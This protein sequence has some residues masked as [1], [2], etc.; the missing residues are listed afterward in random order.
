MQ[1][2]FLFFFTFIVVANLSWASGLKGHVYNEQNEPLAFVNVYVP[3]IRKGTTTNEEGYFK[4]SLPAGEYAVD[5]HFIGYEKKRIDVKVGDSF[6]DLNIIL[7]SEEIKIKEVVVNAGEDPAYAIMRKVIEKREYHLNQVKSFK[8]E[9][10]VKGLQRI[11]S[12]PDKIMGQSV[13]I[14]GV[15][16]SNNSGII[17]LSES[18]S[19][20]YFKAPDKSKE[21]IKSSKVSGNSQGFTWNST[22]GFQEFNFYKNNFQFDFL[23]DRLFVSPTSDNAFFYYDYKLEGFFEEDGHIINKIKVIPKRENDPVFSGYLYIVED[24][25]NIHSL[26]L[27]LTKKN[28]IKF[29]DTLDITQNYF[30]LNDTLWMPFSQRFDFDFNI[31]KIQAEGYFIAVYRDYD[32]NPD[33]PDD[34]FDNELLSFKDS[35]NQLKNDFWEKYRPIPLTETE[36]KDYEK[37]EKL[38]ELRKSKSYLDSMDRINNSFTPSALVLGYTYQRSY[39]KWTIQTKSLLDLVQY[40]NVE[41]FNFRLNLDIEKRFD[42]GKKLVMNP[43]FR[44]GLENRHFNTFLSTELTYKPK[45]FGKVG[46]DFGQYVFQFNREKPIMELVNTFYALFYET[47]YLK[48]YQERFINAS[49]SQEVFNGFFLFANVRYG[50]R[51]YLQNTTD[52]KVINR[53]EVTFSDNQPLSNE[54]NGPYVDHDHAQLRLRAQYRPGQ[55]YISRPNQK[56]IFESKWPTF[57]LTYKKSVPGIFGSD[58]N[59]D[60]LQF[61]IKQE[62]KMGLFG[63]SQYLLKLGAFFNDNNVQFPDYKHFN[64]NR[65]ILG[66]KYNEGFQ[67]LHYYRYSTISNYVEVHYQHSFNGF[68]LNKIPGIRKANLQLVGGAHFIF[69]EFNRDYLEINVGIENILRVIRVDYITSFSSRQPTSFGLK[70]GVDFNA[71]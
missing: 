67:M 62:I 8:S 63:R 11:V 46:L 26:D 69:S 3:E 52:L 34:M 39:K 4:L 16:D 22:G 48:I 59:F 1:V 66:Q 31:L 49:W 54:F 56:L 14:G 42:D 65:T 35:V 21:I 30:Q 60:H 18:V 32:I 45:S 19:D 51:Q 29:I 13:N 57:G 7:N 25:W 36:E 2:R 10:Y 70:V 43:A 55:K 37:K 40:N 5:F 47:N 38:E 15:L 71:F 23:T 28:D 61:D 41:G 17:Y 24:S 44:Y 12:A 58:L 53:D 50:Q 6:K 68:L 27:M 20:F 9:V 64:G 33:L